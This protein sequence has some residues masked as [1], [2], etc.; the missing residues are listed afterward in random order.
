VR[1]VS[2]TM[3]SVALS[4]AVLPFPAIDPILFQIGPF[5]VRW[6]ALAYIAGLV[7]ATWYMKRLVSN[8]KLWGPV[9]PSMTV[10]QVDDFFLWSVLGVVLG[11]RLGYVLFYKPFYYAANPLEIIRMWDGGMSFHGGFLG[12]VVA[13]FFYGRHIGTRLDRMLDLGAASVPVGLGLGRLSN[14]INSELWGRATDMPWAF[15]FPLDDLQLPRHPSQLYEAIL[16]GLVLF[17]A[18]RVATHRYGAL[19]YAGRASGIFALGYGL[20]RIVVEFF[21]EPDPFLG[22]FAGFITMGMILSLPLC[23]IGIWLLIRSR[24]EG[25]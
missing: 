24:H 10:R 23:A 9:K 4:P 14:F 21:R 17:L 1:T 25:P 6:Y 12:V 11:G 13:C 22:Y 20:S 3:I 16:E 19:Q 15:I 18:V 2:R 7:F 8:P 5:A